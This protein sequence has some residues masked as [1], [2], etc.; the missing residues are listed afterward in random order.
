[1][2]KTLFAALMLSLIGT[3]FAQTSAPLQGATPAAMRGATPAAMQG[4]TLY[5]ALSP[6]LQQGAAEFS[7]EASLRAAVDAAIWPGDIV[8]AADAY[9]QAHP[10]TADIFDVRK[11][12]AASLAIV[13]RSDITIYRSSF[14]TQDAAAAAELRLAARGDRAAAIRLARASREHDARNGTHRYTGWMQFASLLGDA[15]A[16]YQ[17]ALHFR[18]DGQLYLA[19]VYESRAVAL[20]YEPVESLDHRR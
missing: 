2:T 17:L 14:E 18:R 1:M 4:A 10:G 3:S 7:T 9:L 19:S 16:S 11:A 15:G 8:R 6:R 12:A 13:R 5:A 20:G